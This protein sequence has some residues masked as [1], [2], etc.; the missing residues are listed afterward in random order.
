MSARQ[1]IRTADEAWAAGWDAPCAHGFPDLR[2]CGDCRLTP[3]EIGSLAV[4]L[5]PALSDAPR[6]DVA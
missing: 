4:L 2:D 1:S 6:V 5:R 3:A